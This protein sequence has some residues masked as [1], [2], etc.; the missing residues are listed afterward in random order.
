MCNLL[1]LSECVSLECSALRLDARA[2]CVHPRQS[3]QLAHHNSYKFMFLVGGEELVTL[4]VG[5]VVG[6]ADYALFAILKNAERSS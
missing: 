2:S 1:A 4:M 6:L 3:K 5:R